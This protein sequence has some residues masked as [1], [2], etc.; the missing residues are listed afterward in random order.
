MGGF[1]NTKME[2][3]RALSY[4]GGDDDRPKYIPQQEKAGESDLM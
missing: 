2:R 3:L 1:D 4:I